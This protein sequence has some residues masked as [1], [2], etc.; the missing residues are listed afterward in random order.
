[1]PLNLTNN[2]GYYTISK[3]FFVLIICI[4]LVIISVLCFVITKILRK[5]KKIEK[6]YINKNENLEEHLSE[7]NLINQ[8][9]EDNKETIETVIAIILHDLKS[10]LKFM[11]ILIKNIEEK[12][13]NLLDNETKVEFENLNNASYKL[14]SFTENLLKWLM[15]NKSSI[16]TEM[17][18][19][20][21]SEFLSKEILIYESILKSNYNKL[22]YS[23]EPNIYIQ[24]NEGVLS[25]IIRN[26]LDN[27]NKFSTKSII[28][29]IVKR[30]N[31]F[32][33]IKIIDTGSGFIEKKYSIDLNEENSKSLGMKIIEDFSK[34]INSKYYY[35]SKKGNGAEF[36]LLLS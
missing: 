17:K 7:L 28:S 8:K 9:L 35:K 13:K 32:T 23:I 12:T 24:T 20:N 14:Y 31:G 5:K 34:K 21:L 26:V 22:I 6:S 3:I 4:F 33:E 11:N 30:N 36:T 2:Q 25:T 15:N 18:I 27:A 1:M 10:P 19:V 16:S 29:F